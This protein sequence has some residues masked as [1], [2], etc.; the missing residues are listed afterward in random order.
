MKT[1]NDIFNE[2]K[3]RYYKGD[4]FGALKLFYF[5]VVSFPLDYESRFYIGH[6][7]CKLNK[8]KLATAVYTKVGI[9]MAKGGHPLKGILGFKLASQLNPKVEIL[10]DELAKLYSKDS[11]FIGKGVRLSFPERSQ[12]LPNN[13]EKLE[14]NIVEPEILM[15]VAG[16]VA[17]YIDNIQYPSKVPPLPLLSQLSYDELKLVLDSTQLVFYHP[18]EYVIREREVGNNF[19]MIL[20]GVVEVIK[21][22]EE[23]EIKL[24]ELGEGA[25]FGE[26][27]LISN[28]PRTASVRA[29]TPLYLLE[30]NPQKLEPIFQNSPRIKEVL[31]RFATERV[32]NNL[33]ATNPIFK[34]F[35]RDQKLQLI[36]RFVFHRVPRDTFI[37]REGE[38]GRGLFLI[39]SGTVR[40]IKEE[41]SGDKTVIATLGPGD[42]FGEISLVFEKSTTASVVT[43]TE[44]TVMFLPREYFQK[45]IENIKEIKEYF[46]KLSYDR[47]RD[48]VEKMSLPPEEI[49]EEMLLI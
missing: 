49:D 4:Y 11:D 37:I 35:N 43:D 19:Y 30:F 38:E 9:M 39:I 23:D 6:C 20:D 15:R 31:S 21:R 47:L 12:L 40:V 2:A 25:I 36:K 28:R 17:S 7:L 32:L 29:L 45:L 16:E 48:T 24:T 42:L 26:M 1:F 41:A 34:P 14:S 10:L 27:A 5:I 33:L 46:V 13:I 3:D 22:G 44:V 18:G 8:L